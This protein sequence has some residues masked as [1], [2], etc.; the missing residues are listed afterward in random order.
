MS[1]HMKT[2]IIIVAGLILSIGCS[3]NVALSRD[4]MNL[5]DKNIAVIT[6]E[7]TTKTAFPVNYLV[8]GIAEH[9]F[10]MG[11][12]LET[13]LIRSGIFSVTERGQIDKLLEERK[14]KLADCSDP[15]VTTEIGRL[16]DVD[17]LF[18]VDSKQTAMWGFPVL[19]DK[20]DFNGKIIDVKTGRVLCT[21]QSR[22]RH[23]TILCGYWPLFNLEKGMSDDVVDELVEQI[24]IKENV[25]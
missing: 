7:C 21:M 19:L 1:K 2:T 6:T 23:P 20:W 25:R 3:T 14:L 10:D 16:T 8:F 22:I 24:T 13:A 9:P 15:D 4:G 12:T 18:L 11:P 17:A 5:A